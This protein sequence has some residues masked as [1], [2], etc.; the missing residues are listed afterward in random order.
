M[1]FLYNVLQ[2]KQLSNYSEKTWGWVPLTGPVEKQCG[3]RFLY[4]Q[5]E[6]LE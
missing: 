1:I 6:G 2:K 3:R 5:S 4:C